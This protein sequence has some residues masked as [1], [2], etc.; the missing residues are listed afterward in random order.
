MLSDLVEFYVDSKNV[1]VT[2]SAGNGATSFCL[3]CANILL[4][5]NKTILYYNPQNNIESSFVKQYYPRVY[6]DVIFASCSTRDLIILLQYLDFDID[7]LILDPGDCLMH[8]KNLIPG[9]SQMIRGN[10]ICTSQIRQDPT[11]G[12]QVYSTIE[13]KYMTR[14]IFHYSIWIRKVTEELGDLTRKYI[15][16]F[17][18]K[19][20]GNNYTDRYVGNF[21]K[22][23]N[24]F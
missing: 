24:V 18:E 13:K 1:V 10:I 20:S 23:G 14:G 22:E 9:L 21:T 17:S 4:R 12:G 7:I 6:D 5:R 15:D 2:S 16:I 3:Y 19:R 11:K 8:N